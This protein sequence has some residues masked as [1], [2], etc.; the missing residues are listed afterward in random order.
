MRTFKAVFFFVMLSMLSVSVKAQSLGDILSGIG[1][2]VIGD[3]ATT[4]SSLKGTWKYSAPACQFESEDL[5]AKAGG[6][7]ATTKAKAVL[8]PV[9]KKFGAQNIVVKFEDGNN[10]V[11]T[12]KK[13]EMKGTYTFDNDKKTVTFTTD[14]GKTFTAYA[15]V[16]GNTMTLTFNADKLMEVMKTI[17]GTA[18]KLSTSVAAL[19]T[20]LGKYKGMKLGMEM[21]K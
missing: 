9:M 13:K 7:A 3:K 18:S 11:I 17:T 2:A 5:L 16:L 20:L 19:N 21:K 4:A 8:T 1:K 12:Y 15:T 14:R 10:Y 6:E